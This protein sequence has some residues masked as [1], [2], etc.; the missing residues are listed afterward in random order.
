MSRFLTITLGI[1]F[2]SFTNPSKFSYRAECSSLDS[3]GNITLKIW[4]TK[5][6]KRFKT[7]QAS[8]NAVHCILYS[9]ISG[10]GCGNQN[11]LLNNEET[12]EKFEKENPD[13]FQKSGDYTKY[14][15]SGAVV[16]AIPSII[17]DKSWK[18]YE[19]IVNKK[20]LEKYLT[21]KQIKKTLNNGF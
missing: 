5:K 18:V 9:G 7:H 1:L 12:I 16:T 20:Q 19:V 15:R 2:I 17:G 6:G 4:D 13:F 11:P 8:I 21:D 14:I 10:N 3:D